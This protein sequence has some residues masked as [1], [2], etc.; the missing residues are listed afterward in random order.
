MEILTK[1]IEEQDLVVYYMVNRWNSVTMFQDYSDEHQ[2]K[3]SELP[4]YIFENEN[5]LQ[6]FSTKNLIN[7]YTTLSKD[8]TEKSKML[9]GMIISRLDN[10]KFVCETIEAEGWGMQAS[11]PINKFFAYIEPENKNKIEHDLITRRDSIQDK[12]VLEFANQLTTFASLSG[13][14]ELIDN[15]QLTPDK[16]NLIKE[17]YNENKII[18][19]R[20]NYEIFNDDIYSLGED[21]IKVI[22]KFPNLDKELIILNKNNPELFDVLR[23]E[24][25]NSNSIEKDSGKI[26]SMINYFTRRCFE[27]DASELSKENKEDLIDWAIAEKV[28]FH[29]K[30]Q[31]PYSEN[32]REDRI[33]KCDEE[34]NKKMFLDDKKSIFFDKYFSLCLNEVDKLVEGYPEEFKNKENEVFTQISRILDISNIEELDELYNSYDGIQLR[35]AEVLDILEDIQEKYADKYSEVLKDT[36]RKLKDA[37]CEYIEYQGQQIK[38]ITLTGEYDIFVH[39]SDAGFVNEVELQNDSFKETWQNGKDNSNHVISMSYVNQDFM[40][41]APVNENGVMYGF[42]NIVSNKIGKMGKTDINT[43]SRNFGY[44]SKDRSYMMP[45]NITDH[46]RR[47]YNEV[48]VERLNT[49]PDYII[50]FSDASEQVKQNSYKAAAEFGIPILYADKEL[51]KDEQLQRLDNLI[52]EFKE[53]KDINVFEEILN[54]YETNVAGWLLNRSEI[55]EDK[56]FTQDIDNS[57]FEED[58]NAKFGEITQVFSEYITDIYNSNEKDAVELLNTMQI[59]LRENDK[60]IGTEEVKPITKTHISYNPGAFI[61]QVNAT[62]QSAGLGEY[63]VDINNLPTEKEYSMK[64]EEIVKFAL[65]EKGITK[66]EI[67]EV[68]KIKNPEKNKGRREVGIDR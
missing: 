17:L 14:L 65:K 58:F 18:L 53:T 57:K 56:S 42:T 52:D 27:I 33:A 44:E 34:Y 63:V 28:V 48:G 46:S 19:N 62:L 25:I 60:Y 13:L 22:A 10:E 6:S 36:D 43:Y 7:L 49:N 11:Y 3:F 16:L 39:S 67:A 12:D 64:I 47:V 50:L 24:I 1:I 15:Q 54:K 45:E 59:F 68:E 8:D 9:E 51:I 32:Y 2:I 66:E 26:Q 35:S 29:E 61:E 23:N 41:C 40:G 21:F 37:E 55:E 4:N 20:M 30:I 38:Q 31:V 5:V